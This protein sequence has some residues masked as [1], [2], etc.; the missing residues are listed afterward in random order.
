M[1][2]ALVFLA[3]GSLFIAFAQ[4]PCE[5]LKS[6]SFPDSTITAVESVAAKAVRRRLPPVEEEAHRQ[7][8]LQGVVGRPAASGGA[9]AEEAERQ[10]RR[11]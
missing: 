4:N 9:Q 5:K 11:M 6:T 3:S 10:P 2:R 1:T 8:R 7:P